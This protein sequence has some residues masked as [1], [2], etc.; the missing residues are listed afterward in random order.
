RF[1]VRGS[2]F[3]L[4]S[5][6]PTNTSSPQD[7]LAINT[8]FICRMQGRRAA[9]YRRERKK[10]END[11]GAKNKETK[12]GH[13]D[14]QDVNHQHVPESLSEKIIKTLD[15]IDTNCIITLSWGGTREGVFLTSTG[16]NNG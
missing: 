3:S 12:T 16:R 5:Q 2:W 1:T 10:K 7:I 15:G 6:T 13:D 8:V 4:T 11:H 9:R 14:Q